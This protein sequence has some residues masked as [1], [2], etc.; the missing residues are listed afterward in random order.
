MKKTCLYKSYKLRYF[1]YIAQSIEILNTCMCICFF[2]DYSCYTGTYYFFVCCMSMRLPVQTLKI[3]ATHIW[4][5][6]FGSTGATA[7]CQHLMNINQILHYWCISLLS[8][9]DL[10]VIGK[11]FS[12][13]ILWYSLLGDVAPINIKSSFGGWL[14][15]SS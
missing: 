4:L 6:T 2:I 3:E 14:S 7:Q 5:D 11:S 1:D 15:Y 9:F 10:L 12:L 8:G 13:I